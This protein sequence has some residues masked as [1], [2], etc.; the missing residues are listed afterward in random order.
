MTSGLY[1]TRHK[2]HAYSLRES[3]PGLSS[4]E[5]YGAREPLVVVT[6]VIAQGGGMHVGLTVV[7]GRRQLVVDLSTI[8]QG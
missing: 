4:P 3:L 7:V 2:T 5:F 8:G 6:G 1:H